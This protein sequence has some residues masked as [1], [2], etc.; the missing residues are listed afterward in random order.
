MT[1]LVYQA[2]PQS[3]FD[4]LFVKLTLVAR[5]IYPS[6][7]VRVLYKPKIFAKLFLKN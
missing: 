7:Q 1:H 6:H 3:A 2:H 4:M 5:I